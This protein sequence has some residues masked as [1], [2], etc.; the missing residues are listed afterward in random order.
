MRMSSYVQQQVHQVQKMM[1]I[2]THRV[3]TNDLKEVL[4]TLI[5]HSTGK[6]TEKA[7]RYSCPFCSVLVIK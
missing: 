7:C 2:K 1:E 5:P 3:Q 6:C 4:N